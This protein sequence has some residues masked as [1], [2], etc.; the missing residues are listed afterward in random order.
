MLILGGFVTERTMALLGG[1]AL[2]LHCRKALRFYG[3]R[4]GYIQ[5]GKAVSAFHLF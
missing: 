4:L 3:L 2:F 1:A 5:D